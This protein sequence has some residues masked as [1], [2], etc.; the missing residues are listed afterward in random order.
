M[1]VAYNNLIHLP[2]WR[3]A[4]CGCARFLEGLGFIW[5]R[6]GLRVRAANKACRVPAR[7]YGDMPRT[8]VARNLAPS[9][10]SRFVVMLV[11]ECAR[12]TF[13]SGILR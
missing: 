2:D 3:Q 7:A 5:R 4:R 13:S 12:V 9:I 11:S 10:P 6:R 8:P 1:E